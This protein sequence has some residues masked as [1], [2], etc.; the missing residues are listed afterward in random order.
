MVGFS[1][2]ANTIAILVSCQDEFILNNFKSFGLVDAGYWYLNGIHKR[3]LD[4]SRFLLLVGDRKDPKRNILIRQAQ[5]I[6]DAS[7]FVKAEVT[8]HF[9]KNTGH[10]FPFR[11]K[12]LVGKWLRNEVINESETPEKTNKP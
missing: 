8:L 7:E 5:T 2:G 9:M 3:A 12:Q 10:Q 1:N 4:K 6:S 11:Y